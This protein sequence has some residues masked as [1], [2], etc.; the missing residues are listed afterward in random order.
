MDSWPGSD[1][2]SESG[3]NESG[4][5]DTTSPLHHPSHGL[6]NAHT[7]LAAP[8]ADPRPKPPADNLEPPPAVC[9]RHRGMLV[10]PN[11]FACR[12]ARVARERWFDD[13][14][15]RHT[16]AAELK[17]QRISDCDFCDS[18]GWL[19]GSDRRVLDPATRCRHDQLARLGAVR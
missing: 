8:P 5:P 16:A 19:L 18:A 14:H 3:W 9:D 7:S 4:A 10:P 15:S 17:R 11:C 13:A 2:E 1:N 6:R 12:D